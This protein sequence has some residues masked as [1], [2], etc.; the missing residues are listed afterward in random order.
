MPWLLPQARAAGSLLGTSLELLSKSF[1]F[2][3]CALISLTFH[4]TQVSFAKF[5]QHMVR[6][7]TAM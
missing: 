1:N 7:D 6:Q 2:S 5:T 4:L 3:D